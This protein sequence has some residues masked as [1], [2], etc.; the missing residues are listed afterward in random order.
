MP[1]ER[2]LPAL[3]AGEAP[4]TPGA[5][6]GPRP[7]GLHHGGRL[8]AAA[9]QYGIPAADWLDLSTGINPN[10]FPVPPLPAA[11]W[12][13]L[14]EEGDGLEEAAAAYYGNPRLLALPGSQ[15]AIQALP[16]LLPPAAIACLA[17]LYQEH[18]QAW[19]RAGHKVRLLPTASLARALAAAT[20]RVLL[21][22]PNNPT[23]ARHP[24]EAVL[25]AA[26]QLQRRGGWLFVDEAFIDPEPEDS[27]T[28][29]AGGPEAPNLVVLRSLGKFFGLAGARV[30]F[31]FGAPDLLAALAEKLGPWAVPGP[32]RAAA[33]LALEDTGWQAAARWEL[34]RASR[35]LQE[36]LAP[37]GPVAATALFASLE[38]EVADDL[39]AFLARR[40]ILVRHFPGQPRLRF[41][42]PGDE[43][44]WQRLAAALDEWRQPG[45][46]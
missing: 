26:R 23:A 12:Q 11:C 43:A 35:R 32:S 9:R 22:N 3:P 13:R 44:Q 25:D 17:P 10:G 19:Q 14:P 5:P 28:P 42:L 6:P 24:R 27:V 31:I 46:A 7:A 4:A 40:G 15:A 45:G 2:R 38:T 36:L 33:R 29:F 41:G 21:C 20:P 16:G 1:K 39:F 37:L 8:I 30:G 34:P 18:P